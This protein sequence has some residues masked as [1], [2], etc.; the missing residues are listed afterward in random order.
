METIRLEGQKRVRLSIDGTGTIPQSLF[1]EPNS[2]I[3]VRVATESNNRL[4]VLYE[5]KPEG[6][7]IDPG[8]TGSQILE[9]VKEWVSGNSGELP[10]YTLATVPIGFNFRGKTIETINTNKPAYTGSFNFDMDLEGSYLTGQI[11]FNSSQ[12]AVFLYDE[13]E[14]V[15]KM[16]EITDAAT[17]D[18][19]SV[20]FTFP[21]DRDFILTYKNIGGTIPSG[22]FNL[23]DVVIV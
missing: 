4:S 10:S 22:Y 3:S 9:A 15:I 8:A 14:N 11:I 12:S 2:G 13:S 23:E 5:T 20:V 18:P 1:P 7:P 16:V 17:G 6:I 19:L 21:S